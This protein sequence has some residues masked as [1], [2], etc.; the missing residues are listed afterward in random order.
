MVLRADV[1]N[2]DAVAGATGRMTSEWG[3]VDVLIANA[4]IQGPIGPFARTRP[5]DWQDVMAVDLFGVLNCCHAVLPQMT[6]RRSGKIIAVSCTG[7]AAPRPG[8]SVY[9]AAKA[10]IARFVE[11]L[12]EEV[13]EQNVQ[14][15]SMLPGDAYT[16]MTD[17][18]LHAAARIDQAEFDTAHQ[19]RLTGGVPPDKQLQLALFLASERSNHV[20]GKLLHVQDDWKRLERENGRADMFTLRRHLK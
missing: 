6:K 14:V 16:T 4:G 1:T 3:G 20:T 7:A 15:N 8:F 17:E 2:P 10:A 18:V 19:V 9:A 11:C 12:A 13:R 5:A